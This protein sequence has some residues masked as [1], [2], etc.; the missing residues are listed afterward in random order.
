MNAEVI[1]S[2]SRSI[3][4]ASIVLLSLG[5]NLIFRCSIILI[6]NLNLALSFRLT[7]ILDI[8]LICSINYCIFI[9]FCYSTAVIYY[10]QFTRSSTQ[11]TNCSYSSLCRPE[12]FL[13]SLL[14]QYEPLLAIL[15]AMT[16]IVYE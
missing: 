1:N 8:L 15:T 2:I 3:S 4:Y 5:T 6:Y 12:T 9:C 10:K 7:L 13:R 14:V 11:S 16:S